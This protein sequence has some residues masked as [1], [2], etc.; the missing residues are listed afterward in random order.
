MIEKLVRD[1]VPELAPI[2]DENLRCAKDD[3]E[4]LSLL[5]RKL[6]EEVEEFL[7]SEC[8]EELADVLEVMEALCGVLGSVPS[9]LVRVKKSKKDRL[10]GFERRFVIRIN[11]L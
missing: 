2:S 1:M 4:F 3:R 8:I 10:G 5:R 7:Q 11:D 9:D 6:T